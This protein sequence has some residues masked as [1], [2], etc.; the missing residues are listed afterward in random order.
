MEGYDVVVIGS[1]YGQRAYSELSHH[2]HDHQLT[3]SADF[4]KRFGV[5]T[6]QTEIGYAIPPAWQ[7]GLSNGSSAGGILG[8]LASLDHLLP[9]PKP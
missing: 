3:I 8:L 5:P 2:S 6:D 4:V 7:S 9:F 1:F